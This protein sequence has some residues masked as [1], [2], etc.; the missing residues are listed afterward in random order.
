MNR[1]SCLYRGSCI[2]VL[3]PMLLF[4]SVFIVFMRFTMMSC[5]YNNKAE[6]LWPVRLSVAL[7][8]NLKR[9]IFIFFKLWFPPRG[10]TI[11]P[12]PLN[13]LPSAALSR[14]PP[15]WNF[16]SAVLCWE[17]RVLLHAYCSP[18]G[19]LPHIN[20]RLQV[21]AKKKTAKKKKEV[22]VIISQI[23]P[24]DFFFFTTREINFALFISGCWLHVQRLSHKTKLA[25]NS[26]QH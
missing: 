1:M 2:T 4:F 20:N 15:L 24:C 18:L 7:G 22:H 9:S 11:T 21:K 10:G 26:P 8:S 3:I 5:T 14:A 19:T 13:A 23:C 16:P 25:P 6:L 12:L 17:H